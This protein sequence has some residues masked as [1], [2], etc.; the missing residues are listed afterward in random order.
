MDR[1][2]RVEIEL[3]DMRFLD[4][5]IVQNQ[6]PQK[7]TQCILHTQYKLIFDQVT[8]ISETMVSL[9]THH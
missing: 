9:V 4:S 8:D 5:V 3:V 6:N 1:G 7:P 2:V